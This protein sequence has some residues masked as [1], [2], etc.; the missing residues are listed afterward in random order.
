MVAVL[1]MCPFFLD[2]WLQLLNSLCSL[3][4]D[5]LE[6]WCSPISLQMLAFRWC[7]AN[8]FDCLFQII[9]SQ[10]VLKTSWNMNMNHRTPFHC[11]L[12]HLTLALA[13]RS[14]A[15]FLFPRVSGCISVCSSRLPMG[16]RALAL[17]FVMIELWFLMQ[18]RLSAQRWIQQWFPAMALISSWFS[19][20]HGILSQYYGL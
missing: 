17:I 11:L 10:F 7:P 5:S 15:F 12:V 1:S 4:F 8:C 18:C 19:W 6:H 2:T 3:L 14:M 13:Q 16:S 9:W 20:S